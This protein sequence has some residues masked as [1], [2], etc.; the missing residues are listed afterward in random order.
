MKKSS[1]VVMIVLIFL[2]VCGLAVAVRVLLAGGIGDD[3]AL[4]ATI[5]RLFLAAEDGTTALDA[6]EDAPAP[7]K[8]TDQYVMVIGDSITVG[9]TKELQARIENVSI[10][11]EVGRGMDT[12][13][14]IL[15]RR[16]EAGL[17]K[18]GDILVVSLANNIHTDSLEAAQGFV[19]AV[20]KGQRLVFVTGHGLT[21]MEPLNEFLRGLPDA[22]DFVT[23][24][25]WDEAVDGQS[26][27]LA[28]DGIHVSGNKGNVLYAELV[29]GAIE[30]ALAGPAFGEAEAE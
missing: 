17:L 13:L 20:T 18:E 28:G 27:L 9:A 3:E 14:A 24:A 15:E 16:K 5:T 8:L 10:D 26:G 6:E 19:D 21:N 7:A 30:E 29:V 2:L 12:G 22:Y 25:D 11:A 23:V 4:P 1:F